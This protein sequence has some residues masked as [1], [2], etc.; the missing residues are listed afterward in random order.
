MYD[1]GV[2]HFALR[3]AWPPG[4]PDEPSPVLEAVVP[5]PKLGDYTYT[6]LCNRAELLAGKG[7]GPRAQR[8]R[9]DKSL[10]RVSKDGGQ[11]DCRGGQ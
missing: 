1:D 10:M 8:S 4:R 5:N 7:P 3:P 9:W 2:T 6:F 11:A